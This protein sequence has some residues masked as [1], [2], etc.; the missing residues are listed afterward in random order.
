VA[1]QPATRATTHKAKEVRQATRRGMRRI[2]RRVR[3]FRR[4]MI[5]GAVWGV[6]YAPVPGRE[7]RTA[8]ARYLNRVPYLR[9]YIGASAQVSGSI[10]STGPHPRS[11]LASSHAPYPGTL[12]DSPLI[13]PASEES[14]LPDSE[15]DIASLPG[16]QPVL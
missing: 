15:S 3:W 6:L 11:E 16:G 9:D 7:A 4:G 14:V 10:G 1:Q 5:A 13:E 12:G 8:T 2:G